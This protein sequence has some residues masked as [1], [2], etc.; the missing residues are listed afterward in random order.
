MSDIGTTYKGILIRYDTFDDKWHFTLRGK[1]RREDTVGKARKVID[2]PPV[3][4]DDLFKRQPIYTES[5]RYGRDGLIDV[6]ATSI[7]CEHGWTYAWVVDSKHRRE[8]QNVK[9]C[10]PRTPNNDKLAKQIKALDVSLGKLS[11]QRQALMKRMTTLE[12]ILDKM[13]DKA[14]IVKGIGDDTK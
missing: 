5:P 4:A 6:T 3:K 1:Q 13:N 14:T 12:S 2:A 7:Q 9:D 10:Y 11:K 8:K